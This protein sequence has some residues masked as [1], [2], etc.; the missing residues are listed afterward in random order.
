M[1]LIGNPLCN[2]A[3]AAVLSGSVVLSGC[4]GGVGIDVDAPI[5]EAAGIHLTSKKKDDEDLP[6]R[7]GIVVPPST[8][9]LPEPGTRSAAA[10]AAQ[11]WPQDPDQIK[12]RKAEEDAAAQEKYCNEG[13]WGPKADISEFD[14]NIGKQ[15]RC[16]SKLGKAISKN[17]NS[18]NAPQ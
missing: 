14:K 8:E 3:I 6:E 11:N 1:A 17:L 5:L 16:A 4:G 7:A 15:P 10:T 12:K 9:K 2:L 18:G 13:D